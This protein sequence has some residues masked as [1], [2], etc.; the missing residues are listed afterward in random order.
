MSGTAPDDITAAAIASFE[1]CDDERLRTLAQSLTRHLHAFAAEVGLTQEEWEEGI[2]LL[3]ETG[4]ITDDKRQEFI[5]WSD[6]LGLS[7]LVDALA[8][9]LPP[10][11]R[12]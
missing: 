12:P 7:M 9:P 3:T 6:A 11:G 2:R 8:N 1:G 10:G 4:R 5:L